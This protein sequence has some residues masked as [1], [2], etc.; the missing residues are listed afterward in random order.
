M[1]AYGF[2]HDGQT[3]TP[4]GR[5]DADPSTVDARNHELSRRE[6]AAFM[7]DDP[8]PYFAYVKHVDYGQPRVGDRLTRADKLTTWMGD[9]LATVS[10]AGDVYRCAFGDRRQNFRARGINGADYF[11][12][13][14]VSSGDYVR[15][16]PMAR[17]GG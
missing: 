14:Y 16:R 1:S 2:V 12:T 15:M 9:E 10:W 6:V 13:A 17:K 4:S 5:T 11:G 8:G 7:S 3:F